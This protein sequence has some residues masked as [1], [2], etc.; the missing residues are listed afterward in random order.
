MNINPWHCPGMVLKEVDN[1]AP[2]GRPWAEVSK[3][4]VE[5]R[6]RLRC[7]RATREEM[8]VADASRTLAIRGG[9]L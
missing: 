9:R 2:P 4:G 3:V 6:G 8:T 7:V 1:L 5:N